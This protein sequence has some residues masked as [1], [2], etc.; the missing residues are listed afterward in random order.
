M[1]EKPTPASSQFLQER[2]DHIKH[3]RPKGKTCDTN[4]Q[5]KQVKHVWWVHRWGRG[6]DKIPKRHTEHVL[7]SPAHRDTD[8]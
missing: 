1:L 3:D 7:R 6:R 8:K 4:N 5:T 2:E